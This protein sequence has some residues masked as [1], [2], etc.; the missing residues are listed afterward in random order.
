MKI[1]KLL[2]VLVFAV[3]FAACQSAPQASNSAPQANDLPPTP[4]ESPTQMLGRLHAAV[5]SKNAEE[6]KNLMSSTTKQF[7]E[8]QAQMKN[9]S[10]EEIYKN[11]FLE[12][13]LS[14]TLPAMR[15]VRIKDQFA[16]VEAQSPNGS[17]QDVPLVNEGGTWKVAVGDIFA[18]TYKSPAPPASA[19]NANTKIPQ[20]IPA[21]GGN[22]PGNVN[23]N[24]AIKQPPIEKLK[25]K[26][27]GS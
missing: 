12:M 27:S 5:Q 21:P 14:P 23:S 15:D 7:A 9:Q 17:W 25:E 16:G 2:F 6:I 8:A 4:K 20:M 1:V 24:S 11:G 10:V 13:N 3:A 18:G 26:K 22:I 19:A